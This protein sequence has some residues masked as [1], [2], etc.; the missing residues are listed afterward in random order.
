MIQPR[1][2]ITL[3]SA[4]TLECNGLIYECRTGR[5]GIHSNKVE[6]DGATP[7]GTYP[8]RKVFYRPDRI[9]PFAC[10][11]PMSS[12]TPID[13]WCD[14]PTDPNYNC[15]VK[16]PYPASHEQL[17]RK[18][19]VYDILIVVGYNDAPAIPPKGSAIFI[20]LINE[21]KT[22]TA[23]CIALSRGDLIE[24]LGEL[25]PTTGLFIPDYLDEAK[26]RHFSSLIKN[27]PL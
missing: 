19:H 26:P 11:L 1:E 20:H 3:L 8:L 22:P 12:L 4:T 18:D 14:D 7:T 10:D 25:T 27:N 23:G 9:R 5:G 2:K 6:G 21:D 24:I 16:T 13:G 17:W 15:L